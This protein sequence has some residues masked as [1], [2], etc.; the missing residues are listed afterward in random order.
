MTPKHKV[1]MG[2]ITGAIAVV[3]LGIQIIG[4]PFMRYYQQ[5]HG[6]MRFLVA[7][8]ITLS[9]GA[10]LET[11]TGLVKGTIS[12]QGAPVLRPKKRKAAKRL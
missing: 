3:T 12:H 5:L 9:V 8:S 1:A 2:L 7:R 11:G 6:A 4:E 10:A